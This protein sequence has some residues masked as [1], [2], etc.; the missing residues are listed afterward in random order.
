VADEGEEG[1][2]PTADPAD[3]P[4]AALPTVEPVPR[5]A[6]GLNPLA[7][8]S[9]LAALLYFAVAIGLGVAGMTAPAW[10]GLLPLAA[11]VAG[12]IA[13]EQ[14]VRNR[15]GGSYLALAGLVLGFV[16]L[17]LLAFGWALV[18]LTGR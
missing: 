13:R 12:Y 4:S 3:S 9:L 16:A 18:L 15:R 5:V 6:E 17:A 8:F 2:H 11:V 1:T 7:V 10:L 14:T